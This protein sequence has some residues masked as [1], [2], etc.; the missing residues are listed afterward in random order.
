MWLILYTVW[1]LASSEVFWGVGIISSQVFGQYLNFK[2]MLSR[3]R[4]DD[5]NR[6]LK[7]AL[8]ANLVYIWYEGMR[9]QIQ[10]RWM[11]FQC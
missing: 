1:G 3:V 10:A 6:F 8:A 5:Y 11:S 7:S 4:T 9:I 2:C